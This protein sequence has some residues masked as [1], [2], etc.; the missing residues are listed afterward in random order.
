MLPLIL[1]PATCYLRALPVS[2]SVPRALLRVADTTEDL[3][4]CSPRGVPPAR[5]DPQIKERR[6]QGS[7]APSPA[8]AT[9]LLLY[10]QLTFTIRG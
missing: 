2:L 10:S 8:H 6:G 9:L 7:P 4:D 5:D 1:P 3:L